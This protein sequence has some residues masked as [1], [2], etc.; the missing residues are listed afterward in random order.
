MLPRGLVLKCQFYAG[1]LSHAARASELPTIW[2]T[3]T[4]CP[5]QTQLLLL[6]CRWCL[7][8]SALP[9]QMCW[10]SCTFQLPLPAATA[11]AR[12]RPQQQKPTA[13]RRLEHQWCPS[14][15]LSK[16][17]TTCTRQPAPAW[18]SQPQHSQHCSSWLQ[19]RQATNPSPTAHSCVL[20]PAQLAHSHIL[21]A[22]SCLLLPSTP[23]KSYNMWCQCLGLTRAVKKK[24]RQLCMLMT[25][26]SWNCWRP[27]TATAA[28]TALV[29]SQ[30]VLLHVCV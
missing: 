2:H 13:A 22:H 30:M 1:C 28:A 14:L 5:I 16:T 4:C 23:S 17:A 7:K 8:A 3:T 15:P 24:R 11:M 29:V 12:T 9:Q 6:C 10:S 21:P 20:F 26:R 19:P 18:E 25:N 27:T